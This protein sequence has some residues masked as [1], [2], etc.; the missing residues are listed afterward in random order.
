MPGLEAARARGRILPGR[1]IVLT[2]DDVLATDGTYVVET[3]GVVNLNGLASDGAE[4]EAE[5]PSTGEGGP[6]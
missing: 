4:V 1:R 5:V 6:E 3:E 2:L